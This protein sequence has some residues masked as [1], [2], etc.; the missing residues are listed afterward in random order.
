MHRKVTKLWLRVSLALLVAC[1]SGMVLAQAAEKPSQSAD[2]SG[3]SAKHVAAKKVPQKKKRDQKSKVDKKAEAKK[4]EATDS[5]EEIAQ[6]KK[7]LAIQQQQIAQLLEAMNTLQAQVGASANPSKG[8]AVA[9]PLQNEAAPAS[10]AE[11]KVETVPAS[12]LAPQFP[13][14]GEVASLSPVLPAEAIAVDT[15]LGSK[16][17]SGIPS[18]TSSAPQPV[19]EQAEKHEKLGPLATQKI[20]LGVTFFGDYAFY[21]NTGFG[22]QFLTQ[23]NQPGPGNGDF[24]SFDVT[25]AYLNF[26]YTPIDAITL[27]ITPNVYRQI[28]T[29]GGAQANGQ[30]AAFGAS[31]NGN[32]GYRLKYAYIDFNHPFKGSKAFGKDKVTIGQTTNPLIDWEEGLYGYR[33]V[34]LVPW[35]YLSLSS[36]YGGFKVHGPIEFNGKEYLDYDL[37]VFNT[38]SFHSLELT[39][40]KQVMGR[41]TWYPVGTTADRTGFGL[42]VFEDYGYNTKTPDTHSTPGYRFATFAHYQT[43]NKGYLIAGEF[44]MGRNVFS[45]GNMFSGVGPVAGGPYGD[46][47]TLA[48]AILAGDRTKQRGYAFF[49]HARLGGEKSPWSLFGMYEFWQPNTNVNNDPLDFHRV[50]GGISYSF[51]K[52]LDLALD[53]QNLIYSH[54]QFTFPA[55]ELHSITTAIPNAVPDN[56]NAIFLNMQFNY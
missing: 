47:N 5:A 28:N 24:N 50:V 6:L 25:R 2:V 39:D 21:S 53:S 45:T 18:A 12:P 49:G 3:N 27:R 43:H 35:N 31:D 14:A 30:G 7:Q 34:N 48:S 38:A 33:Y 29:S 8:A 23:I 52:Y 41:L 16:I 37:G 20:K 17:T 9:Q 46:L 44:D 11:K 15:R 55:N 51:S 10:K 26:Y 4:Q 1:L 32:L 42:T 19:P 36:T 40:K 13:S 54:S 56:T 22:P